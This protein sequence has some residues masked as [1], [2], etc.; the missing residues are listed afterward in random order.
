MLFESLDKLKRNSI[1]S[2]IL[3]IFLGAIIIICPNQYIASLTLVFG[4]ALVVISIIMLLNYFSSNKAL[5]DYIKFAGGLILGLVG[6]CVL[7]FRGDIMRVLAG[8]FGFLLILDGGRTMLHAFT[9]ARRSQRKG[10]WVLAIL[11]GLL[12]LTGIRV[13]A[14]PW[15]RTPDMLMKV[16]GCA[17]FFSAIVS[18]LRLIWTWPL[19]KEKGGN[20]DGE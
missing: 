6:I 3:L 15:W 11:S 10:W 13:F 8:L 2:S 19:R 7:A 18:G 5:M 12:M 17:I 4:Y 14:N 20:E 1:M 9:Y 16:I